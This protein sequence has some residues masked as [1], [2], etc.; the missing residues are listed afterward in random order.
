MLVVR[1][2]SADTAKAINHMADRVSTTT[3]AT[4]LK[5]AEGI[6]KNKTSCFDR[7]SPQSLELKQLENKVHDTILNSAKYSCAENMANPQASK[8][9]IRKIVQGSLEKTRPREVLAKTLAK[10]TGGATGKKTQK[11][12][13]EAL[14]KGNQ[15]SSINTEQILNDLKKE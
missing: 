14:S 7:V 2:V 6:L 10:T 12:V 3:P 1:P 11:A 8:E 13:S 4:T 5:E 9:V 15:A